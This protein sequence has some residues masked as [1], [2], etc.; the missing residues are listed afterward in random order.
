MRGREEGEGK[1]GA[2]ESRGIG[3]MEDRIV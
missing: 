1:R 2:S 3:R